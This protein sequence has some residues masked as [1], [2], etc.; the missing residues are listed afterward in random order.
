M[1]RP[2]LF[3]F[4][5]RMGQLFEVYVFT[6][7][8]RSYAEAVVRKLNRGRLLVRDV[9]HREHCFETRK[10]RFLKD[11]RIVGNRSLQDIVIIDNLVESFGL[12]LTN[13][14]PIL[15]FAGATQDKELLNIIPLMERISQAE[16]VRTVLKEVFRLEN[17]GGLDRK[18]LQ[19]YF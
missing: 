13:G 11:L 19:A 15:E 1:Y 9:M 4:L 6:A 7:A 8:Q 14:V 16:D 3:P 12:Q 5:E 2:H 18:E 17:V 10:G